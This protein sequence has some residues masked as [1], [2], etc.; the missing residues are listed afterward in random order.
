MKLALTLSAVIVLSSACGGD[1]GRTDDG[2]HGPAPIANSINS[3]I[4]DGITRTY[5]L[6]VPPSY[7]AARRVPLVIGL[8]GYT[9]TAT[10]FEGQSGFSAKADQEGFLVAYP[11]GLAYP[12][13]AT[14]AS[15]AGPTTSA[16]SARCWM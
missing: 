15:R 14:N 12:G 4:H 9:A 3:L 13:A 8:H 16:S 7:S 6:H 10:A 1:G 2:D 5:L 11:N